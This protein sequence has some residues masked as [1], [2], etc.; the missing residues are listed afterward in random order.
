MHIIIQKGGQIVSG[1]YTLTINGHFDAGIYQVFSGFSAGDVLGLSQ[2]RPEWWG[3]K[4]DDSTDCTNALANALAAS[5]VLILETGT[6]RYT[7]LAV[8]TDKT[9]RGNGPKL[10]ILGFTPTTGNGLDLAQ[11]AGRIVFENA[12]IYAINGST[13]WAIYDDNTSDSYAVR[14]LS[15]DKFEIEGFNNGIL[16]SFPINP[17]IGQGRLI[18]NG[19]TVSG[20]IGI[21]IGSSP[22][23]SGYASMIEKAYIS[24]YETGYNGSRDN[25]SIMINPIIESC[26]YPVKS[27]GSL[28]LVN[29]YFENN[30]TT[31][32]L[33]TSQASDL[34]AAI[35]GRIIVI[36]PFVY[37]SGYVWDIS[38]RISG[39]NI[40]LIQPGND[41]R[42][43]ATDDNSLK[44]YCYSDNSGHN[45]WLQM[46]KSHQNT[47]GLTETVNGESL[48]R[49][50]MRGVN[51]SKA[52][53]TGVDVLASQVGSAGATYLAGKL[54]VKVGT[55]ASAPV[56]T[57]QVAAPAAAEA[58]IL[59]LHNDG[60]TC[61]LKRVKVLGADS[62]G[63]GYRMLVVNN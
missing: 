42:R 54:D 4:A 36:N 10:S 31:N 52:A 18:G 11:N 35:S 49:L 7:Q 40:V 34:P 8:S 57:F 37:E 9:I 22:N 2:S 61:V 45:P 38:S 27:A 16:L 48:A 20:T 46:I 44:L 23:S 41:D 24:G 47:Y 59:V 17:R 33:I 5:D 19:K 63:T 39:E 29:P 28:T 3:G 60:S 15:I 14:E 26:A 6:Y 1:G 12:K 21:Q 53:A 50:T 55:N 13:G 43:A 25:S 32:S 56:S 62:G 58:G 30:T 51:S